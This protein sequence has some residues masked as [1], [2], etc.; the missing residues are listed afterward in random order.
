MNPQKIAILVDSGT[1]VPQDF[2]AEHG[3]YMVPLTVIYQD[4]EYKDKV[5]ISPQEVYDRLEQEVPRTSLPS[6]ELI[7][8]AFEQMIQDGYEHVLVITISSGLSGTNNLMRLAAEGFPQLDIH[9]VDTKNI[10]FGAGTQA[11]LAVSQIQEGKTFR[12]VC[13]AVEHSARNSYIYFCLS[14]LEYLAKG[15]RIGKVA[16]AVGTLLNL[17]P[18]ITCNEEGAY[19]TASKVRGRAQSIAETIRVATEETARHLRVRIGVVQGSAMEEGRRVLEEMKRLV[20]NCEH[21]VFT[22]VSPAL[23]VHTGPGLLGISVQALP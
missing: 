19:V 20:K 2:I 18:I 22:D 9:I 5:E 6:P 7:N 10:G 23:V 16:A 14:T 3:L 8:S 21:F 11:L 12:E 13:D 1:D 15:G 4:R 17:K